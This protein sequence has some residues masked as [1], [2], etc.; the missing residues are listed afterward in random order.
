LILLIKID[1]LELLHRFSNRIIIT[2]IIKDELNIDLPEWIEVIDPRDKHYQNILEMDL[3]RGE[4]SAISLMLEIDDAILLIDD[5]KGR[6]IADKLKL[7]FSGTFGFLLKAKELGLIKEI[8]PL[9]EKIRL[10]N[11]RFSE[12]VLIDVLIQANEQ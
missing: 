4:A 8:R 3:D 2:S 12:K 7:K 5:L 9:I 11:F 6:K 10:T 1:E